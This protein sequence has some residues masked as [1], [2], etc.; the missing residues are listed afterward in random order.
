[1]GMKSL[2]VKNLEKL[3][4]ILESPEMYALYGNFVP[5]KVVGARVNMYEH[6]DGVTIEKRPGRWWLYVTVEYRVRPE[7]EEPYTYD[8]A[9]WKLFLYKDKRLAR[10]FQE[11]ALEIRKRESIEEGEKVLG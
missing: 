2:H 3:K 5:G 11:G 6:P 4:E 7:Q 1:M 9:L 10:L 8:I